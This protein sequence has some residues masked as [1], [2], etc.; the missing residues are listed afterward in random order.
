MKIT[1]IRSIALQ[2]ETPESGWAHEVSPDENL[3][4][5]VEVL[6]DEGLSGWGRCYTSKALVDGAIEVLLPMLIGEWAIETA[7]MLKDYQ[8]TWFEEALVPDDIEGFKKLREHA[9][10]PITTGEVITRRQQ[11]LPWLTQGAV[12]IIQPDSTKCGGL[13]EA[14][15]IAWM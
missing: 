5:L 2:G 1:E 4:T 3:H 15:R 9:P 8:V 13:S 11:F 12:D 14:R 7:R 10:L 6:T